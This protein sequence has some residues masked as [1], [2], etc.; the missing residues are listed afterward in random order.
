MDEERKSALQAA[1]AAATELDFDLYLVGGSV[2]DL[3]LR[4]P[5]IDLDL[6]TKGPSAALAERIAQKTGGDVKVYGRFATTCVTVGRVRVDVARTRSETYARPGA[7]PD[8]TPGPLTADLVRRDFTTNAMA[9]GLTGSHKGS[10]VDP[11]GG[12]EDLENRA[13]RVIHDGSFVDDATRIL[14]GLRLASRLWFDIQPE[15]QR[16]MREQAHYLRAISG[17]RLRTEL[18]FLLADVRPWRSLEGASDLGVLEVLVRGLAWD[19]HRSDVARA[20][21]DVKR[22]DLPWAMLAL[23]ASTLDEVGA[24]EM[25]QRFSLGSR[26]SRIVRQSVQFASAVKAADRR[27]TVDLALAVHGLEPAV[28]DALAPLLL[29]PT[30]AQRLAGL[31]AARPSLRGGDLIALGL[32]EGPAVGRILDELR[33]A[34]LSGAVSSRSDELALARTLIN[35]LPSESL[36]S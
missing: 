24:A 29:E 7:L 11:A 16:L 21:H 1:V 33:R 17:S 32:P 22:Q 19:E 4:R 14:R 31:I 26:E 25:T 35:E 13:L 27:A 30:D 6:V 2:R 9:L 20:M 36:T 12:L 34:T 23:L 5:S 3:I 10:L 28:T 18:N 8:V 15:T